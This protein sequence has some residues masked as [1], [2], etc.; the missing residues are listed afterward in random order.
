MKHLKAFENLDQEE[1]DEMFDLVKSN[2]NCSDDD[3][4]REAINEAEN[5][6]GFGNH[7]IELIAF[8]DG[9]TIA[10]LNYKMK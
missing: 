3:L 2:C 10:A 9:Y 1:M 6:G 4:I 7:N 5:F 8:V